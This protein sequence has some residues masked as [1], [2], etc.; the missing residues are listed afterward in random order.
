MT[1]WRRLLVGPL[2]WAIHFG[3]LYALASVAA[4][5]LMDADTTRVV[6][7]LASAVAL[8]IVVALLLRSRGTDANERDTF[9]HRARLGGLILC[10]IAIAW[11][12]L[13]LLTLP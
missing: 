2:L 6:S 3:L 7:L 8:A 13:P 1:I 9:L 10:A 11:Q 4:R 5:G 12:T